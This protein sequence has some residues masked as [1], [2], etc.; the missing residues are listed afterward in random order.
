[1]CSTTRCAG[2]C[3]RQLVDALLG[4]VYN[5]C[6][7]QVPFKKH[8]CRTAVAYDSMG[9]DAAQDVP[10]LFVGH[11]SLHPGESVKI[12][13]CPSHCPSLLRGKIDIGRGEDEVLELLL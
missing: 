1:M 4:G 8:S 2:E 10:Y 11:Q 12:F 3:S 7:G 5:N 9:G 6:V 13:A